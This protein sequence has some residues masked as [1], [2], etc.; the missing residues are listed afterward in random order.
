[1]SATREALMRMQRDIDIA[2]ANNRN[3]KARIEETQRAIDSAWE[4]MSGD[5]IHYTVQS[6]DCNQIAKIL[7]DYGIDTTITTVGRKQTFITTDGVPVC[8]DHR[9]YGPHGGAMAML[10]DYPFSM[11]KSEKK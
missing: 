2:K 8:Y 7:S 10:A 5:G 3:P 4:A 9:G 1:M 6:P 11:T